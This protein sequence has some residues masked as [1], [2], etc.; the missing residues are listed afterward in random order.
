MRK[1]LLVAIGLSV[2]FTLGIAAPALALGGPG[3]AG[4]LGGA[5]GFGVLGGLSVASTSTSEVAF[6]DVGVS[7]GNVLTGFP[8]GQTTG[9]VRN[10]DAT[11]QTAHADAVTAY[12]ALSAMTPDTDLTG[13]NLGGRTLHP[14]VYHYDAAAQLNGVLT[15]D[16]QGDPS[17]VFVIQVGS[18]LTTGTASFATVAGGAQLCNV[19]WEIGDSATLALGTIF[20]AGTIIALN[21]ITLDQGADVQGRVLAL[22]GTVS[23]SGNTVLVPTGC[24]AAPAPTSTALTASPNPVAVGATAALTATV[25]GFNPTGTVEFLDGTT[26][27]GT[28][29]VTGGTATLQIATLAAGDHSVTAVYS[30][31]GS[32]TVSTSPPITVTVA[33]PA[34]PTLAATGFDAGPAGLVGLVLAGAGALALVA[35]RRRSNAR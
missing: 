11:A 7:P 3:V 12:D 6:G 29:P 23:M 25:T 32:N 16:A 2:A 18:T 1:P 27:L 22:D 17:A 28:A 13:Q 9:T 19:Y 20:N 5:E 24:T 4:F 10:D 35:A 14:G 33:A 26:S 21:S 30:G 8:P 15:L 34:A 31:D